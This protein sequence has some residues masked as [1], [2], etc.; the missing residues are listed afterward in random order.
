MV[1]Y[2]IMLFV[3]Y[4]FFCAKTKKKPNITTKFKS[5]LNE[6]N[7]LSFFNCSIWSNN[8]N[9]VMKQKPAAVQRSH[10]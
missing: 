9:D 6:F 5:G 4:V 8:P 1:R 3:L 10:R 2:Y 7:L